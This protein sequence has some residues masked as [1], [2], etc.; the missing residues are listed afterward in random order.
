L[1]DY[2]G[3]SQALAV[4][5]AR[6]A[7]QRSSPLG[8]VT[9]VDSPT[10]PLRHAPGLSLSATG[11][12]PPQLGVF[13]DGDGPT[14]LT[15]YDG[16]LEPLAYLDHLTSALPYH[17]LERPRALVLGS[18]AGADVLQAIYHRARSIDAVELDPQIVA[19][20]QRRFAQF[21][22]DPYAI[23]GVRVHIGEARGYV[24]AHADRFDLI[25]VAL[26]DALGVSSAALYT[27]SESYLY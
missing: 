21:S 8:V 4:K 18:G 27:L 3:L 5:D 23:S 17:L 11:E 22:G 1:S 14:A 25:Q 10:I 13:V 9:V 7:E 26:L 12:P 24:A 20:V 15:R 6:I 19:L 16:R 2:K